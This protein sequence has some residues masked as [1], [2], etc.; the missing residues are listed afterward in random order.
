MVEF[1]VVLQALLSSHEALTSHRFDLQVII[2]HRLSTVINAEQICV[3]K[4]GQ[5]TERGGHFEL[6]EK[7]GEYAGMWKKQQEKRDEGP[8]KGSPVAGVAGAKTVEPLKTND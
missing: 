5:V 2:A 3:L 8:A 7:D 6:I 4:N 1:A